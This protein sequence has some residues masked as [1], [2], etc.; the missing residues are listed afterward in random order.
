MNIAGPLSYY[1]YGNVFGN[2]LLMFG[3]YHDRPTCN[4]PHTFHITDLLLKQMKKHKHS[5]YFFLEGAEVCIRMPKLILSPIIK[6]LT[7]KLGKKSHVIRELNYPYFHSKELPKIDH[8]NVFHVMDGI[9]ESRQ[10][11]MQLYQLDQ[12]LLMQLDT[13]IGGFLIPFYKHTMHTLN[14]TTRSECI[15][16]DIHLI[17]SVLI[18]LLTKQNITVLMYY[19]AAHMYTIHKF[20]EWIG[21]MPDIFDDFQFRMGVT[22]LHYKPL[23]CIHG[24]HYPRLM[25]P[26]F[27]A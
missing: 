15:L 12:N 1:H 20:F 4:Q 21:I 13:F 23:G 24:V 18:K 27:I 26:L 16:R 9:S 17:V 3:E 22:N 19:G 25:P 11:Y 6:D 8:N 14:E 10:M 7:I 2:N 5:T